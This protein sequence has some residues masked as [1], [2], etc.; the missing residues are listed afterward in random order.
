V[1]ASS[2]L[3]IPRNVIGLTDPEMVARNFSDTS[4]FIS[5]QEITSL[6]T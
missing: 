1:T 2:V 5:Q 3:K 4:V 6:K